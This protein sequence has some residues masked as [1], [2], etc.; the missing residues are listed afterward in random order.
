MRIFLPSIL[1]F[2]QMLL[3]ISLLVLLSFSRP[4]VLLPLLRL[5]LRCFLLLFLLRRLP[6][7]YPF[8]SLRL[9]FLRLHFSPLPPPFLC[10]LLLVLCRLRRG[11]VCPRW[12]CVGGLFCSLGVSS[13]VCSIFSL[14][15]ASAC[16]FFCLFSASGCSCARSAFAQWQNRNQ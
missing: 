6:L 2:L 15:C 3:V 16:C 8:L 5:F 4:F 1:T 12:V 9:L 10:L 13:S 7:L 14:F 11:G